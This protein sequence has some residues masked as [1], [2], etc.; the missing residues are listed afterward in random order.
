M[1]NKPLVGIDAL[2][3]ATPLP[4]QTDTQKPNRLTGVFYFLWMENEK[5]IPVY[6]ISKITAADPEAGYK[7]D[8]DVWGKYS[9]A[10]YWGEPFYGYYWQGDEWVVRKHMKLL[11]GAGVDFLFFDTTNAVIY[12]HK[13]KQVMRILQEYHDDGFRV[14]QV[15]FYTNTR[16]GDTVQEIYDTVY[17]PQYCPDIWF[18]LDGKPVIIAVEEECSAETR[19]FFN[20]KKSQW[21][22]EPDKQG[23][24]PWMDFTRPQ[25]VFDDINGNPSIIN[26]SV[27]QHPQERFGDQVL[28]GE[29]RNCGRAY[30]N[31][32]NDPDE[33][34][35]LWGYNF[36]EQFDRALETAPPI[37]LITGWNE[38]I[39]G[40]WQG[41][42]ER[43]IMFVDCANCE[44]S[45]D[46]EMMR[47]GY[48]DNYYM[49]LVSYVRQY[50]GVAGCAPTAVGEQTTFANFTD[51]DIPRDAKG[52]VG[53]YENHT[54]RNA[55]TAL[56]VSHTDTAVTFTVKTKSPIVLSEVGSFMNIFIS[57]GEAAG[58]DFVINAHPDFAAKTTTVEKIRRAPAAPT[59]D[60]PC[61]DLTDTALVGTVPLTW[62]D[63]SITV[64]VPLAM[65]DI[66]PQDAD[67]VLWLKAA[68]STRRF[69]RVDQFYEDGDCAPLGRLCYLY[70]G[71]R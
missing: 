34:A 64:T 56:S 6:D 1:K 38:W 61:D 51:G 11:I 60:R 44:Y 4:T 42:P 10:H 7:P 8:S 41:P 5:N 53:R 54:Q 35:Y 67:F 43:P 55:I 29:T 52:W 71:T 21:P 31:G 25:R 58:F 12:A 2:G 40:R 26:V 62:D 46:L 49:Q 37:V 13:A 23:G 63:D 15:M 39:A 68:D 45:R 16:S 59:P 50:K 69:D 36:A 70:R 9:E 19:A 48:F 3:R 20:I 33:N 24:W 18:C 14:P 65:L 22:N 66:A 17:K 27:A 57:K 28:Y 30:H 47:G 32:Q